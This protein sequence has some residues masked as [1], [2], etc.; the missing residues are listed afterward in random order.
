MKRFFSIQ[1]AQWFRSSCQCFT[2]IDFGKSRPLSP[3]HIR[4]A[5]PSSDAEGDD[6]GVR[7]DAKGVLPYRPLSRQTPRASKAAPISQMHRAMH[8]QHALGVSQS[9]KQS[10]MQQRGLQRTSV[11][12]I[13]E[14]RKGTGN[15]CRDYARGVGMGEQR[16]SNMAKFG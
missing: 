6:V 5:K 3:E 16:S 13:N 12:I 1:Q 14:W 4:T 2:C 15:C 9:K 8:Q 11:V 7:S 10:I